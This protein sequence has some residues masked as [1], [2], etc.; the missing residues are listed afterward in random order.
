MIPLSKRREKGRYKMLGT[1]GFQAESGKYKR[2]KVETSS[3]LHQKQ[4][5]Q[6]I[7]F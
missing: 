1:P 5:Q 7:K 3:V 6:K 2:P 4:Q